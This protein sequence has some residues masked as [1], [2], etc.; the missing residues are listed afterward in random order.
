[1]IEGKSWS[2]VYAGNFDSALGWVDTLL[3]RYGPGRRFRTRNK[4]HSSVAC[5]SPAKGLV[6]VSRQLG[7]SCGLTFPKLDAQ[8]LLPPAA[9]TQSPDLWMRKKTLTFSPTRATCTDVD[10]TVSLISLFVCRQTCPPPGSRPAA[11]CRATE[12]AVRTKAARTRQT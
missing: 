12:R 2:A 1:M 8:P 6:E 9:S 10:A 3:G 4:R 11:T 7:T 5:T